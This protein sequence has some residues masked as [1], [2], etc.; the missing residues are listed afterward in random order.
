MDFTTKSNIS[1]AF[2][3]R[4]TE[5]HDVPSNTPERT[6]IQASGV[7]FCKFVANP[8]A[9]QSNLTLGGE[10]LIDDVDRF[11]HV[12]EHIVGFR[13]LL[14]VLHVAGVLQRGELTAGFFLLADLF[15]QTA[16]H[17]GDVL[18]GRRGQRFDHGGFDF[19]EDFF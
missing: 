16:I 14:L 4:R 11:S 13:T 1:S 18:R 7:Q 6:F 19:R 10:Q 17:T 5:A 8:L 2:S 12:V 15:E 3:T 9:F